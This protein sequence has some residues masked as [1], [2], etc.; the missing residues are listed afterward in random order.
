MQ[1]FNQTRQTSLITH[2]RVANTFWS[3]FKG[4]MRAAP[5]N[6][7]EGLI[8]VGE[9]SIHT[10]FMRFSIDVVYVDKGY[11][12]IR[13]D[14]HVAPNRVGPIVTRAAYVLEMPAGVIAATATQTGDRLNFMD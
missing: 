9:K 10:F 14:A 1:V 6:H 5:L 4:L 8:L 2:G 11:T 7:R 12:V 13:A 3:R